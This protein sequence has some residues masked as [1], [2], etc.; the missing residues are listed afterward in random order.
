MLELIKLYINLNPQKYEHH[1]YIV[2]EG[3]IILYIIIEIGKCL[4]M[5]L[6]NRNVCT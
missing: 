1:I 3:D 6:P 2:G 4:W 5:K